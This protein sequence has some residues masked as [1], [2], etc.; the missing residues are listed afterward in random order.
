MLKKIIATALVASALM[1]SGCGEASAEGEALLAL[2]HGNDSGD[3]GAISKGIEYLLN[4]Q[5]L[6]TSLQTLTEDEKLTLASSYMSL[7]GFSMTDI[8]AI[9]TTQDDNASADQLET[10]KTK[11]L[12]QQ[13]DDA[14]AN[15][16]NALACY[17][18]IENAAPALAG[19]AIPTLSEAAFRRIFALLIKAV[20]LIVAETPDNAAIA[21][22]LNNDVFAFFQSEEELDFIKESIME[23]KIDIANQAGANAG[24]L[25]FDSNA[26]SNN[27]TIY[28]AIVVETADV[29][30][31]TAP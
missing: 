17:N 9:A 27:S 2:E 29:A 8:V 13:G 14:L 15:V 18:S 12:A 6:N 21:T 20:L 30:Y 19:P 28:D 10:F 7:S 22:F 24:T 23:L 5:D 31:Y 4:G 11:V 16:T 3:A 26:F 25:T 1:F